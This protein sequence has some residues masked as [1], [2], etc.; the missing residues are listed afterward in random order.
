MSKLDNYYILSKH[1]L[2]YTINLKLKEVLKK[3]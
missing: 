1:I 2:F 3:L